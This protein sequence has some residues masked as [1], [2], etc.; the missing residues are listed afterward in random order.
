MHYMMEAIIHPDFADDIEGTLENVLRKYDQSYED[1]DGYV[2]PNAFF[3]WYVVGGRFSNEKLI[4]Q[5]DS[6]KLQAFYD[7]L[8]EKKVTV[9]AIMAGKQE[10]SPASQIPMVDSL[11]REFFPDWE[12]SCPLF[13]HASEQYE[14]NYNFPDVCRLDQVP[15]DYNCYHVIVVGKNYIGE[16]SIVTMLLRE[17]WNGVTFQ[18]TTWSGKMMDAVDLHLGRLSLYKDEYG[19]NNTV[20]GDWLA[21]TVD[22][23]S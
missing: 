11:F 4:Q 10:I 17:I 1:E 2:N 6:K 14:S 22:Y 21:V 16:P 3:D 7:A 18:D 13:N 15:P 5:F 19:E 9:S 23:H 12:G 8:K 20:T